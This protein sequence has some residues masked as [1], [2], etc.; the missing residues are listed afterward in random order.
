[1]LEISRK[2]GGIMKFQ[3]IN[4]DTVR[5]IVYKKDMQEFGI[6][7]EDFFKNKGKVHE[8]LHEV[9][10]RAEQ[11]VGYTP[12][13][14]MLSMQ[15]IPINPNMISITFSEN[16]GE[17]FEDIIN[18][19]K[20]TISAGLDEEFI[21]DEEEYDEDNEESEVLDEQPQD[22]VQNIPEAQERNVDEIRHGMEKSPVIMI[23]M[24]CVEKMAKMCKL[25]E[26]NKTVS[27]SLYYLKS[28]DI[29]CMIIEKNRLSEM[30]MKRILI[31]A[32]E[33]TSNVTDEASIIS[34]IQE[35]GEPII[36]KGAYRILRKY[37]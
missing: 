34:H 12:K 37:Y 28:K 30:D 31:L 19:L 17:G 6:G 8:F 21:V 23:A 3:R 15:I 20:D 4:E 32:V 22:Y 26:I 11:E 24:S 25:I 10:E 7:L 29:Y 35:Y 9:V 13:E 5:C 16:S 36:E 33:Y 2:V 18:N 27:S 14:G 1:M